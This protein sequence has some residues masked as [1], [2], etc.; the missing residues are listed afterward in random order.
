MKRQKTEFILY[1][2][3]IAAL[4]KYKFLLTQKL[5]IFLSKETIAFKTKV[6]P[7]LPSNVFPVA[8]KVK[9]NILT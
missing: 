9:A 7:L 8:F 6:R 1:N 4:L 5:I 2:E 3:I